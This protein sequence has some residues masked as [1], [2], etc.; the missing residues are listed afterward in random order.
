MRQTTIDTGSGVVLLPRLAA[1]ALCARLLAGAP[2]G[3][4][5]AWKLLRQEAGDPPIELDCAEAVEVVAVTLDAFDATKDVALLELRYALFETLGLHPLRPP[6]IV[7][8]AL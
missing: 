6:S 8:P 2:A 5:A 7:R 4:A 3:V 1:R